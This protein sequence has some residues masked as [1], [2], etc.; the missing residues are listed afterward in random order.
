M[1][2][3]VEPID[4]KKTYFTLAAICDQ[5]LIDLDLT[6]HYFN[7]LLSWACWGIAQLKLDTAQEPKTI[8]MDI[9]DV[10]TCTLPVDYIDWTKVGIPWG[11]YVKTFSVNSSLSH[12]DRTPGNPD[13]S[14]NYPPDWLPNGVDITAYGGYNFSNYGGRSIFSVGGGLAHRGQFVVVDRPGGV[15]EMLLDSNLP[16]GT[17]QIYL[18]YIALGINPCGETVLS[19]YLAD[20]ARQ[21]IIHQYERF[22]KGPEKS[23][24]AIVRT[25]RE[26]WS[27]E[28]LV[29]ARSN[30]IDKDTLI[31]LTRKGYR[32][33]NKI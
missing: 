29:R 11:Q 13:F 22:R 2:E 23:E 3:E 21:Y 25:G 20:Y 27:A 30:I 10:R 16:A 14:K 28:M 24:A 8:V 19:P 31:A 9:S 18:E 33:T 17:T 5:V 32:L 15:K 26:L 1:S 12:I 4:A 7:K 6:P